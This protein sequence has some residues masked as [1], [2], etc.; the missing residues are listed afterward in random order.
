MTGELQKFL[1]QIGPATLSDAPPEQSAPTVGD[2]QNLLRNSRLVSMRNQPQKFQILSRVLP[3]LATYYK[4]GGAPLPTWT[5]ATEYQWS[6]VGFC[7]RNTSS[8]ILKAS[9]RSNLKTRLISSV[10]FGFAPSLNGRKS[11]VG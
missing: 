11:S 9:S 8:S 6:Q 5:A 3:C 2:Q 7:A 4:R 1:I 10:P